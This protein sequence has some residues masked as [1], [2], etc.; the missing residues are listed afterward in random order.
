M[1]DP[2]GPKRA[3]LVPFDEIEARRL[4]LG[5]SQAQLCRAADVSEATYSRHVQGKG[6]RVRRITLSRLTSGL[7]RLAERRASP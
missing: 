5:V 4:D 3:D 1:S 6:G 2:T 7:S